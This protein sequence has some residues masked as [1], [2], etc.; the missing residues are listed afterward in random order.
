MTAHLAR[1]LPRYYVIA[2]Q[3]YINDGRTIATYAAVHDTATGATLASV[4]VPTLFIQ[5]GS[6][7]PSI[8]GAADDR[9]FVLMESGG[10][11]VH[12]VVWC[13]LLRVAANGRSVKLRK[14]PVSVP[15]SMA[16]DTAD[17]E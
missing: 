2:F 4:R 6:M 17:D 8:T 13:Y 16:I 9:T 14:V 11:S 3:R 7:A 5:G 12:D 1:S 10:T 15:S